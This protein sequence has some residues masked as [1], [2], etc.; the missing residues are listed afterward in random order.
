MMRTWFVSAVLLGA[1]GGGSKPAPAEPQVVENK[2]PE[3][4]PPAA[5]P[6]SE[7]DRIFAAMAKFKDEMCACGPQNAD[8]AKDV[9]DRMTQWAQ[10]EAQRNEKQP[11][12]TEA[13]QKR[14]TELGTQMGECMQTSMQ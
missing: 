2:Q 14:F 9:S 11:E 6:M 3:T 4:A 13:D 5:A 7:T 10:T 1:C 12:M 8:C